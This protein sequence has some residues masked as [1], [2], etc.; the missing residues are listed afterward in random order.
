MLIFEAYLGAF[1][2]MTSINGEGGVREAVHQELTEVDRLIVEVE[3]AAREVALAANEEE[4]T[5]VAGKKKESAEAAARTEEFQLLFA[6]LRAEDA[7]VE[8][9]CYEWIFD[10]YEAVMNIERPAKIQ[11][12]IEALKKTGDALRRFGAMDKMSPALEKKLEA[13]KT[14]HDKLFDEVQKATVDALDIIKKKFKG[15]ETEF[16]R[17]FKTLSESPLARRIEYDTDSPEAREKALKQEIVEVI[18]GPIVESRLKGMETDLESKKEALAELKAEYEKLKEK[19]SKWFRENRSESSFPPFDINKFLGK[20][21]FSQ[22]DHTSNQ[23]TSI[24][25]ERNV[26][27]AFKAQQEIINTIEQAIPRDRLAFEM[28]R[29]VIDETLADEH[30]ENSL[31]E[32]FVALRTF[33]TYVREKISQG[34]P[35]GEEKFPFDNRL[36]SLILGRLRQYGADIPGIRFTYPLGGKNNYGSIPLCQQ[37]FGRQIGNGDSYRWTGADS[38]NKVASFGFVRAKLTGTT[39]RYAGTGFG[40]TPD[41]ASLFYDRIDRDTGRGKELK[42]AYPTKKAYLQAMF[43]DEARFLNMRLAYDQT[44]RGLDGEKSS[45]GLTGST[46]E[47]TLGTEALKTVGWKE[48]RLGALVEPGQG[49]R[50]ADRVFALYIERFSQPQVEAEALFDVRGEQGEFHVYTTAQAMSLLRRARRDARE[51]VLNVDRALAEGQTGIA[52]ERGS[53]EVQIAAMKQRAEDAESAL[54]Q[55][56]KQ[57]EDAKE[58]FKEQLKAGKEREQVSARGSRMILQSQVEKAQTAQRELTNRLRKELEEALAVRG[59]IFS[60]DKG[61]RE[62]VTSIMESLPS[63]TE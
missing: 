15:E 3:T 40:S 14:L 2:S 58:A 18:F 41:S 26:Q 4:R 16:E 10:A 12:S 39:D 1:I 47:P 52:S 56:E 30:D 60:G 23:Q 45:S 55:M 43:G 8:D 9:Y 59:G 28:N 29:L 34:Q 36:A 42:E 11:T 63:K 32:A 49:V 22:M 37:L 38:L 7:F 61:L 35:V 25:V 27:D 5:V 20:V 62:A 53:I 13:L 51:L 54:A 46:K 17:R 57:L 31:R 24:L 21:A 33:L 48:S 50:D 44:A 19:E 6:S